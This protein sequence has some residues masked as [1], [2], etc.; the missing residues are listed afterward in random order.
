MNRVTSVSSAL[1]STNDEFE[2]N[3]VLDKALGKPPTQLGAYAVL[4]RIDTG[5]FGVVYKA[6]ETSLDRFVALKML[7]RR[8]ARDGTLLYEAR[9]QGR[10]VHPNI[11]DVYRYEADG[12]APFIVMPFYS[13]GSLRGW[14]RDH[15]RPWSGLI[16]TLL[17][18]ARGL[19]YIHQ[20]DLLHL[21]IKP[22]NILIDD[23]EQP[24]LADFGVAAPAST[25]ESGTSESEQTGSRAMTP[26]YASPEHCAAPDARSDQYSFCKMIERDFVP[27]ALGRTPR[28]IRRLLAHGC[29]EDPARRFASM[30][31]VIA[32]LERRRVSP[33]ALTG[34]SSVATLSLVALTAVGARQLDALT[35]TCTPLSAAYEQWSRYRA[36]VHERLEVQDVAP[37]T[38]SRLF[39]AMEQ[40]LAASTHAQLQLCQRTPVD[41]REHTSF[42]ATQECLEAHEL[43]LRRATYVLLT[44]DTAHA[45]AAVEAL[46]Q[47]SQEPSYCLDPA[48]GGSR[49]L[50]PRGQEDSWRVT[51]DVITALIDARVLEQFGMYEESRAKSRDVLDMSLRPGWE[52]VHGNALLQLA[53]SEMKLGE[54][55]VARDHFEAAARYATSTRNDLLATDTSTSLLRLGALDSS[56]PRDELLRLIGRAEHAIARTSEPLRHARFLKNRGALYL[57]IGKHGED[58]RSDFHAALNQLA[59]LREPPAVLRAA[60]LNNLGVLHLS[61]GEYHQAFTPIHSALELTRSTLGAAHPTTREHRYNHAIALFE[62]GRGEDALTDLEAVLELERGDRSPRV[63]LTELYT[64][65]LTVAH[66]I[67]ELDRAEFL[68]RAFYETTNA[69]EPSYELWSALNELT[70]HAALTGQHERALEFAI[71]ANEQFRAVNHDD[72]PLPPELSVSLADALMGAGATREAAALYRRAREGLADAEPD[73]SLRLRAELGFSAAALR[74]QRV[75]EAAPLLAQV[76]TRLADPAPSNRLLAARALATYAEAMRQLGRARAAEQLDARAR[77]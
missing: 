73:D 58:A 36:T 38:S 45:W 76:S 26:G 12:D 15:K 29:A 30:E 24:R 11:V 64:T 8:R 59:V 4:E 65:A 61:A 19:A 62:V 22:G 7:R 63:M 75:V 42:R 53:S 13:R 18:I 54:F 20:Q 70:Q 56:I 39:S 52:V 51:D 21:D 14:L 49:S 35:H 27:A 9:A 47:M 6:Y 60:L 1:Y 34:L 17:G 67:G 72:E 31:K 23:S 43:A 74:D 57:Q 5:G 2:A 48:N 10:Y 28:V 44:V 40:A 50:P 41:A 66:A 69:L 71:A 77:V 3:M 68:A 33:L 37:E 32:L 55:S 25:V 46:Q 16:E